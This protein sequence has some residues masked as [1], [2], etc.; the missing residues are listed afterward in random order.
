M[1]Q[2][3]RQVAARDDDWTVQAADRIEGIVASIHDKTTVPLT[4]AARAVVY[5]IL[6]AF[7]GGT[8]LVLFAII[9]VRALNFLPGDVWV[10]HL[11]V[12][13]VFAGFGRWLWGKRR[14]DER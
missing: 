3:G 14:S 11:I 1:A 12:G 5:G 6:A 9:A 7:A 10:A 2:P 13:M 8:A 4:T